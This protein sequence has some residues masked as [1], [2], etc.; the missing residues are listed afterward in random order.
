MT[1]S[2]T[3]NINR[4]DLDVIEEALKLYK[5]KEIKGVKKVLIEYKNGKVSKDWKNMIINT[6][7]DTIENIEIIEDKT[8]H[9]I[10]TFWINGNLREGVI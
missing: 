1:D 6:N 10:D 3:D 5:N 9:I 4:R 8:Q 2:I 7:N